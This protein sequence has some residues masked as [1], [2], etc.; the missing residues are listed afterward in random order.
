MIGYTIAFSDT[1][2]SDMVFLPAHKDVLVY[3]DLGSALLALK[4]FTVNMNFVPILYGET[5]PYENTT[6]EDTLNQK[7][8]AVY[9]VCDYVIDDEDCRVPIGLKRV[10][11]A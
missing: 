4:G 11:V 10:S 3:S 2:S 6:F 8:F 7:G 9:G 5:F 1:M